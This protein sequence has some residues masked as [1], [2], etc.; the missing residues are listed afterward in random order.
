MEAR[1][2]LVICVMTV[3]VITVL[4]QSAYTDNE[5]C[6]WIAFDDSL[7]FT[8]PTVEVLDDFS[9][10]TIL[11]VTVHGM[12][13]RDTIVGA[14]TFKVVTVPETRT[15]F[16]V[17]RPR[18]PM[19][20]RLIALSTLADSAR[21]TGTS[22]G[23]LS[24]FENFR[25]FPLQMSS[26]G[27]S[28]PPFEI[29]TLFYEEYDDYYPGIDA[30]GDTVNM[31]HVLPVGNVAIYPFQYNPV[32]STL[33][34]YHTLDVVLDHPGASVTDTI[35]RSYVMMYR[36]LLNFD[37]V[38]SRI[39]IDS[40]NFASRKLY[41]VSDNLYDNSEL[42]RYI[43]YEKKK[44]YS[45][46]KI[47]ASEAGG[48]SD[49]YQIKNTIQTFYNSFGCR[50]GP[51]YVV[52]I[53]DHDQIN[54]KVST[55]KIAEKW[56]LE[57]DALSDEWYTLLGP[58][59]NDWMPDLM[60]GRIATNEPDTLASLL[61]NIMNSDSA[62][63]HLNP[64]EIFVAHRDGQWSIDPGDGNPRKYTYRENKK[65]AEA[66]ISRDDFGTDEIFGSAGGTNADVKNAIEDGIWYVNYRGHGDT[67]YWENWDANQQSWSKSDVDGL[68]AVWKPVI[69]GI[70]C[71]NNQIDYPGGDCLGEYWIKKSKATAYF[72]SSR[73]SWTVEN[74]YLDLYIHVAKWSFKSYRETLDIGHTIN[75]AKAILA[76]RLRPGFT[77]IPPA[78]VIADQVKLA[79]LTSLLLGDPSQRLWHGDP[80]IGSVIH[81]DSISIWTQDFSVN[82]EHYSQP[83][84]GVIVCLWKEGTEGD[85]VFEAHYTNAL[86]NASFSINPE[87][88]G[89][90]H[91]T[92]WGRNFELYT[93][94][95]EVSSDPSSVEDRKKGIYQLA[96]D[97]NYP[98]PF[99]QGT[100]IKFSLDCE[101]LITL[102]IYDVSG[103]HVRTLEKQEMK[104]G[105][106]LF[107]WNGRN[108]MGQ[109][110]SSGIYFYRLK[111]GERTLTKK[112]ILL[113]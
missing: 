90:M 2:T 55:F 57:R 72:S 59:G 47:T 23:G 61:G 29:D 68:N 67:T 18:L 39:E 22:V 52:F 20:G 1:K 6:T 30:Q 83:V 16:E 26:I 19:I 15:T 40:L 62:A 27:D 74:N 53:G 112:M 109:E 88:E 80:K 110:V 79:I 63:M 86:G 108:S 97:Q 48:P 105:V 34:A 89:V 4:H 111:A 35:P 64:K 93:A 9:H 46:K 37:W 42:E 91:V 45:V 32:D 54:S 60:V 94:E 103:K 77:P 96:L 50:Y 10:E 44:G 70:C 8:P 76:E 51:A 102:K 3:F 11:R 56:L 49:T 17:G 69:W 65:L 13:V 101:T 31:W 66:Y 14:D 81:P 12:C 28:I 99:N 113:K 95:V 38:S 100:Y 106:Y 107:P 92:V 75:M 36:R 87:T 41:I 58:A 73:T 7:P 78:T 21:I 84:R 104:P 85:E 98:N 24:M 82:V 25:V 5:N 33:L 43:Q 71:N